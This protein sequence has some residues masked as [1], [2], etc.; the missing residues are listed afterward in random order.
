MPHGITQCYLQPGRADIP[1]L[2]PAET[3]TRLSDPGG[4]QGWVD[5]V[6]PKWAWSGSREQFLHRGLRKFRHSKSSVY[7]WA[8]CLQVYAPEHQ[9]TSVIASTSIRN[10]CWISGQNTRLLWWRK[11]STLLTTFWRCLAEP[12]WR[13]QPNFCHVIFYCGS[14]F[15]CRVLFLFMFGGAI[16]E[17]L[18]K[19]LHKN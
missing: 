13:F 10:R 5:L 4:M 17:T 12:Q 7:R 2:T 14:S 18:S 15:T 19:L 9:F 1:A 16:A 11:N 8:S 6:L 3:G